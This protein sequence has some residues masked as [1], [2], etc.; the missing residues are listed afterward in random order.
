[1]LESH[2]LCLLMER[3]MITILL[4]DTLQKENQAQGDLSACSKFYH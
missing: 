4:S 3:I 1:M 2:I